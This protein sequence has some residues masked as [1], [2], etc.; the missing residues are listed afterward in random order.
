MKRIHWLIFLGA[1]GLRSPESGNPVLTPQSWSLD[2][3]ALTLTLREEATIGFYRVNVRVDPSLLPE[4][5][6]SVERVEDVGP[7][8]IVSGAAPATT[9]QSFEDKHL[10][11]GRTWTYRLHAGGRILSKAVPVP[12]D[13]DL[14]DNERV[15][16]EHLGGTERDGALHFDWGRVRLGP[17]ATLVTEGRAAHFKARR[18]EAARGA[19]LLAFLDPREVR[20]QPD[21][22]ELRLEA[23]E[24]LG[25]LDV[26]LSGARGQTGSAGT[27]GREGAAGTRGSD[28]RE[29]C[30]I[31]GPERERSCACE[32]PA[33]AGAN[34]QRGAK[35][36]NGGVGARGGN[37]GLFHLSLPEDSSL[38]VSFR[39][40]GGEGGEGGP[41]GRGGRGGLQ[42]RAGKGADSCPDPSRLRVHAANGARGAA[43]RAGADGEAGLWCPAGTSAELCASQGGR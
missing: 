12:R 14:V 9:T 19:R 6:W 37:G 38:S 31:V 1:C 15:I 28:A 25:V 8:E 36:S 3:G 39:A 30:R 22:G 24:A 16:L 32:R 2:P 33:R 34:G 20:A 23:V 13:L 11:S 21:A 18:F 5:G 43:G 35:G 40:W 26:D 42:G 7:R 27:A 10:E 4:G 41:G 29:R 17:G